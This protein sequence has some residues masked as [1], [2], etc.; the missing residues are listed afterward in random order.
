M[1]KRVGKILLIFSMLFIL[2]STINIEQ[3][4]AKTAGE[5]VIEGADGFENA[6]NSGDAPTDEAEMKKSF[7]S[8]FSLI[9][10]LGMIIDIIVGAILGIQF[11]LA[12]VEEKAEIK[13]SLIPFLVGSIVIFGSI[14]IWRAFVLGLKDIA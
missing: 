3:V 9:Y 5:R 7:Q 11:M 13:Q 12:S 1:I 6:G 10:V 8:M 4:V 14:G 2:L